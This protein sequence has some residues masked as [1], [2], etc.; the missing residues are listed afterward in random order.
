MISVYC[1][2][3]IY[4]WWSITINA[5][6]SRYIFEKDYVSVTKLLN[7]DWWDIKTRVYW[8]YSLLI[9]TLL[10]QCCIPLL[11]KYFPTSMQFHNKLYKI[12]KYSHPRYCFVITV[13][14]CCISIGS[15]SLERFWRNIKQHVYTWFNKRLFYVPVNIHACCLLPWFWTII[16][17][18][19]IALYSFLGG[20]LYSML[21]VGKCTIYIYKK[22]QTCKII[23]S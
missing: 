4:G 16:V 8:T 22:Q 7:I 2:Q 19:V 6:A 3:F 23:D 1:I 21:L 12:L 5:I 20:R 11:P 15:T 17:A 10:L 14:H 18:F 9:C 13:Q